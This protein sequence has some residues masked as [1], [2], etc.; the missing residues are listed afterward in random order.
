MKTVEKCRR[1]P[2]HLRRVGRQVCLPA[3][4]WDAVDD[5]A[6]KNGG[7]SV[8]IVMS[9]AVGKLLETEGVPGDVMDALNVDVK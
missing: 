4:A 3:G 2:P 9:W 7:L 6:E 8:S 1:V 5:Y